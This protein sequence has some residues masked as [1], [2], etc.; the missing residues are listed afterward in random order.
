MGAGNILDITVLKDTI[1]RKSLPV[2]H[3][4]RVKQNLLILNGH[5]TVE[6]QSLAYSVEVK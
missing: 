4:K 2:T 1:A 3:C 5:T 6:R